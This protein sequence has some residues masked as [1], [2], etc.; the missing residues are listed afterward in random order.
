[1]TDPAVGYT[2]DEAYGAL[3]R[4]MDMDVYLKWPN[5]SIV[6][7]VVWPGPAVYPGK[8]LNPYAVPS[9]ANLDS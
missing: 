2:L 4:G 7:G 5:G 6:V 3:D 8:P 9:F 1:M